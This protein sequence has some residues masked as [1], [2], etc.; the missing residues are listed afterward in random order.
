VVSRDKEKQKYS[1]VGTLDQFKLNFY[2]AISNQVEIVRQEVLS[3]LEINPEYES[4]DVIVK[5][6]I[7][8]EMPDVVIPT[9]DVYFDV[10]AS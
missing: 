7:M 10:S 8:K 1:K 3:Y 6:E 2:R 5:A 9:V 4:E